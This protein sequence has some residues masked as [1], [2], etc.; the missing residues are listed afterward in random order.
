GGI[1]LVQTATGAVLRRLDGGA[2]ARTV[3]DHLGAYARARYL[4]RLALSNPEL[5]LR[6]EALPAQFNVVTRGGRVTCA[7]DEAAVAR[8]AAA[9]RD[10]SRPPNAFSADDHYALRVTNEGLHRTFF[11]VVSIR[12]DGQMTQLYPL[13]GT[14]DNALAP[15]A[16]FLLPNCYV[17]T[18][19]AGP[20]VLKVFA[21]DAP[22][23]LTLLIEGPAVA[24]TRAAGDRGL[25]DDLFD[26]LYLEPDELEVATRTG[27]LG[28]PPRLATTS[29]VVLQIEE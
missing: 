3:A 9:R 23:D 14:S 4:Q 16:S 20:D 26:D 12:P 10:A 13:R 18:A 29:E 17:A 8:G 5:R 27:T 11:T 19:P 15:G 28:A 24:A 2:A 7:A 25:L 1:A 21:T 6:V 22:L